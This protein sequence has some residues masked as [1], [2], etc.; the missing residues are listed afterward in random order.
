MRSFTRWNIIKK[1]LDRR[2]A[3]RRPTMCFV[4][5]MISENTFCEHRQYL[6]MPVAVS[7]FQLGP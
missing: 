1:Y 4:C 3:T 7:N 5:Y 2:F 6:T